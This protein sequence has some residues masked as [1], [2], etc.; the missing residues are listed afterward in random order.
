MTKC[1]KAS[2]RP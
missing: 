2:V 1:G